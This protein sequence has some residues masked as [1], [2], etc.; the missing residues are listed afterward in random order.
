MH[1]SCMTG[2]RGSEERL[3]DHLELELPGRLGVNMW[4]LGIKLRFSSRVISV[5]NHWGTSPAQDAPI[6]SMKF[7]FEKYTPYNSTQ[8][9]NRAEM[10]PLGILI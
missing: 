4:V 7:E 8:T 1:A 9:V 3:L 6:V 10:Q 2:A 5:L